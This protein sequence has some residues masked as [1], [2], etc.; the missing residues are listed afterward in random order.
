MEEKPTQH[1]KINT[2]LKN[3]IIV[4]KYCLCTFQR[5]ALID[6]PFEIDLI[7]TFECNCIFDY[8]YN[9]LYMYK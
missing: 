7:R 5:W 6:K 2:W 9:E 4:L 3:A 1:R 8:H